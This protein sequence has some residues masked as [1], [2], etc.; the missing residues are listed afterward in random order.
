MTIQPTT[1]QTVTPLNLPEVVKQMP[2]IFENICASFDPQ[3]MKNFLSTSKEVRQI[4]SDFQKCYPQ[5]YAKLLDRI[6]PHGFRKKSIEELSD[7]M[8][9][10]CRN[11]DNLKRSNLRLKKEEK[12]SR[13]EITQYQKLQFLEFKD[14]LNALI[15]SG[16]FNKV[17]RGKL[18][19]AFSYACM[20]TNADIV[21]LF[22]RSGRYYDISIQ[23]LN[24]AFGFD[25]P[26]DDGSTIRVII[27]SDR[28]QEISPKSIG[29]ALFHASSNRYPGVVQAIM[30]S[31][32]VH[33]VP[34][35]AFNKALTE[36]AR[37]GEFFPE[38]GKNLKILR[39][40][41][42]FPQFNKVAPEELG[43][44]LISAMSNWRGDSVREFVQSS[45]FHEINTKQ[46]NQIFKMALNKTD[47]IESYRLKSIEAI[48]AIIQSNRFHEISPHLQSAC[49]FIPELRELLR[50]V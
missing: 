13:D 30:E 36:A 16:K 23:S 38:E 35:P 19:T 17:S 6:F 8:I 42:Q 31:G 28:F 24:A 47:S 1:N 27:N 46:L 40:L 18:E 5:T 22:T 2:H 39:M 26:R 34:I 10:L 21:E 29:D 9:E 49:K 3:T 7:E 50:I 44:I 14:L 4:S 33:E 20:Y 43:H 48:K 15:A 41:M 32:R 45:R 11:T 25:A 12:L 37:N